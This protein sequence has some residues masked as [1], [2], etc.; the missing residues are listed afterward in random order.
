M[1]AGRFLLRPAIV[2]AVGIPYRR[3]ARFVIEIL[4]KAEKRVREVKEEQMKNC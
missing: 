1:I 2:N 4:R 3:K